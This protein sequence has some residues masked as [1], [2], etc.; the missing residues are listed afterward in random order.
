MKTTPALVLLVT[1][2]C[3]ASQSRLEAQSWKD[4]AISPVTN[5][6]FFED[7]RITTEIRPIFLHH[8]IDDGFLTKGG[9]VRVYAAQLRWAVTDRLAL[10]ATKDGYIEFNP[11]KVLTHEEGWAD[12][13]AGIKYALVDSEEHQFILTPGLKLELPTGNRRVFQGNGSGEWDLFV[14]AAKGWDKWHLTGTVGARIPNDFSEETAQAHAS[15]QLDYYACRWFIPFASA[16]TFTVLS[17]AD[18][19]GLRTE[20]Y[21]LI[22][23]GA[24]NAEGRTQGVLGAGF[25]SRLHKRVDLG[26]AYEKGVTD[27]KGIFDDRFTV[28]LIFRF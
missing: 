17:E 12:L 4:T 22:N 25:R 6:L 10:I 8:K 18:Q 19:L 23:F 7:P 15:L 1:L 2:A 14:S 13:S 20:G 9:D 3:A 28:D 26:F 5:P 21:D 11:N 24:S 16:H 27:P